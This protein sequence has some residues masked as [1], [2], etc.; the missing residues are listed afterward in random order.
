ME[1]ML[2]DEV[3][4]I[5]KPRSQH[6]TLWLTNIRLAKQTLEGKAFPLQ[7]ILQ[8]EKRL[9]ATPTDTCHFPTW[10]TARMKS[11]SIFG[12]RAVIQ[13]QYTL[14]LQ[15]APGFTPCHFPFKILSGKETNIPINRSPAMGPFT[16]VLHLRLAKAPLGLSGYSPLHHVSF[17]MRT[18]SPGRCQGPSAF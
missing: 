15:K 14:G 7:F 10:T 11:K 17:L 9:R 8:K 1:W 4:G 12:W 6:S 16:S 18:L 5:F 3:S 13:Q 2:P